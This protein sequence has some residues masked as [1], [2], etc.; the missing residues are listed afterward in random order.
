MVWVHGAYDGEKKEKPLPARPLFFSFF[1]G[2]PRVRSTPSKKTIGWRLGPLK[3][4]DLK[5]VKGSMGISL[6]LQSRNYILCIN[7]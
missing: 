5:F 6:N 3:L 1:W 7:K 4:N 2:G